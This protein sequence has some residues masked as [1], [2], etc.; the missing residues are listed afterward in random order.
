[1][2]SYAE[3]TAA[4][5]QNRQ[6]RVLVSGDMLVESMPLLLAHM[7]VCSKVFDEAN[8]VWT[9]AGYAP[10]FQALELGASPPLYV[11]VITAHD[12]APVTLT[13]GKLD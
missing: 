1:V 7:M 9:V 2:A 10:G 12:D 3:L 6:G 11:A 4:L 5:A 8:D 13:F